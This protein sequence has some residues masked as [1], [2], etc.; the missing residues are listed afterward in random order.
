M[1][2]SNYLRARKPKKIYM[3]YAA[4]AFPNPSS[5]HELGIAAKKKLENA[6]KNVA[7]ILGSRP[8][9]IIFTSGG[10]EGNNI[11]LQGI[12]FALQEKN[13]IPHIITTNIEHPS[14]LETCRLLE[15][16]N[17]AEI[18]VVEVEPD[19]IVDPK[20]IKK[21]IKSNTV[22]ISVMYANNEIGTIEPLKEIAKEIRHYKKTNNRSNIFFHTDAVQAVNYLDLNIEKLG[23]DMLTLSGSKIKDSGRVGVLYKRKAVPLV[24]IFGGGDQEMGLRAGTE[25]LEGILKFSDALS[26]V[27]KNKEKEVKRLEKLRD[28]FLKKLSR[29]DFILNGDTKNRLPSN[30]NITF[31][32]IPSDLLVIELSARGIMASSKSACKSSASGGSYVIKALRPDADPEIGGLRFSFG[33]ETK[34][35][36]IDYTLKSLSQILTKLKKWYD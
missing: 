5:I 1:A 4:S 36:D 7:H 34:K 14:V 2:K 35:E 23:V 6:R 22:L 8:E 16:R 32:K 29:S 30:I 27:Q 12:V 9:E 10:T 3:D 21:A 15:K 25:N 19:G 18:T 17:L 13:F 24:N 11:A 28:Y 20:K 31:P 33:E 26:V